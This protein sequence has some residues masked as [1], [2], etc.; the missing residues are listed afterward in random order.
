MNKT[1]SV[2]FQLKGIKTEQFAILANQ[3]SSTRETGF[4]TQFQFKIH[5][6]SQ[7]IGVFGVF[8]FAQGKQV[9]MKIEISC[10]FLIA[11]SSWNSFKQSE[12]KLLI[13]KDFMAHLA[14]ITTGTCRGVLFAKTEGTEFS[15][16]I[17]PTLN[18]TEM[19]KE[20][21]EFEV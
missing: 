11:A 18:V 12:N 8:E 7:Q 21:A 17:I 9:F 19:I 6:P 4:Q 5:A 13:P 15:K 3:Y 1:T 10:H 20:D 2:E 14:M 16:F